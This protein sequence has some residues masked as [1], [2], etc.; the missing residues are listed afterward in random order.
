VFPFILHG[1]IVAATFLSAAIVGGGLY[2][3]L[4]VDPFWP[5]RADLVQPDRGGISRGRF[6]LPAHTLFEITLILSLVQ[7][8]KL[9][10]LRF[11]LLLALAS[12]ATARIWSAFDFIPKALAFEKAAAVDEA[13]ARKWTLRSRFRLPLALLTLSL[14]F[15]ALRF[16]FQM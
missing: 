12:H 3:L 2:E 1:S 14:L 11:W 6:W 4:V 10:N 7:A 5:K 13:T 15:T 16:A 8:W 9:Q